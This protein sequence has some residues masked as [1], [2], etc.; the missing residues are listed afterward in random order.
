M[1]EIDDPVVVVSAIEPRSDR[2]PVLRLYN[3]SA[4]PRTVALRWNGPGARAIE[5]VDLKEQRVQDDTV[6]TEE[7]RATLSLR[8]W[9]I[10][11]LRIC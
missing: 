8:P 6:R 10:A 3:A 5:S 4:Q 9:G 1:V 11:T 2:H 7:T